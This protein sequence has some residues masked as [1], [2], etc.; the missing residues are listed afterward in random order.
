MLIQSIIPR[1]KSFQVPLPN[2][3]GPDTVYVFR[4]QVVGG[5]QVCEIENEAH[6][7]RLLTL[8]GGSLFR[9]ISPEAAM[10]SLEDAELPLP[11]H[12]VGEISDGD[13]APQAS[14]PPAPGDEVP[15]KDLIDPRDHPVFQTATDD[16]TDEQLDIA[17][18]VLKMRVSKTMKADTKRRNIQEMLDAMR[19]ND[20]DDDSP[21]EPDAAGSQ[22]GDGQQGGSE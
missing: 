8:E 16:M 19:A 4:R 22:V 15:L 7:E 3:D 9:E 6:L 13:P 20:L 14:Q 11:P 2:T 10:V 12:M 1:S 18:A 17:M 5:P 21:A